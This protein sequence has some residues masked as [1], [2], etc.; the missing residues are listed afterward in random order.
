MRFV[1]IFILLF[2]TIASI[3]Q[4]CYEATRAEG[5]ALYNQK[6][7]VEAIDCF[8]SAKTCYDLPSTNDLTTQINKCKA[9]LK[10]SKEAQE[11]A[12]KIS[13]LFQDSQ[14]NT[15]KAKNYVEITGITFLNVE[16]SGEII[17]SNS[18]LYAADI[19]YLKGKLLV[20]SLTTTSKT[21]TFYVKIY[22][23]DGNL[24]IGSNSPDGY[25][26]SCEATVEPNTTYLYMSGWGRAE[27][28]SYKAG[29][30]RY[31]VWT[32]SNLLCSTT[33][34]LY[35]K[36]GE[37]TYLSVDNY[38]SQFTTTCSDY[39]GCTGVYSVSTDASEWSVTLLPSWIRVTEKT[40]NSFSI[41][42]DANPDRSERTDYFKVKTDNHEIRIDVKQ[43]GR[44]APK[45]NVNR[46]W[47]TNLMGVTRFHV[48]FEVSGML[49]KQV[50]VCVF[51]YKPNR[52]KLIT[53]I[54]QHINTSAIGNCPYEVSKWS[55]F[56]LDIQNFMFHGAINGGRGNLLFDVEIQDMSG[57]LLGNMSNIQL[58]V[59]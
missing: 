53:L 5:I 30:Y 16:G 22:S 18:T 11:H 48:D 35:K 15:A 25:T 31:E 45:A 27:K 23:P 55:N 12:N 14:N 2:I 37:S 38:T 41:V 26:F 40:K 47:T 34:T 3:A 42:F 58:F 20:K 51:F 17:S 28:G 6:K 21:V 57:N 46:V 7:Y 49:G 52:A 29:T 33:V 19:K 10:N 43:A 56:E 39:N 9:A 50:N 24:K 32:N 4:S 1:F 54:G 59:P 44:P 13:Q 36:A 8:E